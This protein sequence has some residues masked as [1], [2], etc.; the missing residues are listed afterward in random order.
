M[1]SVVMMCHAEWHYAECHERDHS[2]TLTE[3]AWMR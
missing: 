1:L 2:I 3:R